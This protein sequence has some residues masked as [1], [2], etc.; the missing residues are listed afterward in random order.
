MRRMLLQMCYMNT[1]WSDKMGKECFSVS[2]CTKQQLEQLTE[3]AFMENSNRERASTFCAKS[4]SCF[5]V[6]RGT[7]EIL[8]IAPIMYK[9]GHSR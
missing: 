7:F 1:K 8:Y 6:G 5:V 9:A 3:F 4:K 2:N